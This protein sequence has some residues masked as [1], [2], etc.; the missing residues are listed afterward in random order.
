MPALTIRKICV[1]EE[2]IRI[3]ARPLDRAF[4]HVAVG[5][6][7]KNPWAGQGFV[8]DL[9]PV[10]REIAPQLGGLLAER[11][12]AALGGASAVQA[13]GKA[14][15]V[16]LGGEYEHANAL[17]HTVLF[18]D[19]CRRAIEGSA[20]M[21]SNQKVAPPGGVLEI[22]MAHKHDGKDQNHYHTIP[23]LLSDAPRDDE[24]VVA[25]AMASGPRPSARLR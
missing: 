14:A 11:A 21:V 3:D 12:V 20:W 7:I 24:I 17:I 25:V 1:F 9:G 23:L 2:E 5:A 22:P 15:V 4:R 10:V 6:I 8:E 16:G 13:F 18:G 19:P